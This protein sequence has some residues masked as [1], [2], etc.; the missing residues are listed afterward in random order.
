MSSLCGGVQCAAGACTCKTPELLPTIEPTTLPLDAT[1]STSSPTI[2]I[3]AGAAGSVLAA[4]VAAEVLRR[5]FWRRRAKRLQSDLQ[6][7]APVQ[8]ALVQPEA[9]V[10]Q[11][12]RRVIDWAVATRLPLQVALDQLMKLSRADEQ[13]HGRGTIGV[14]ETAQAA[15]PAEN[16][17]KAVEA[18]LVLFDKQRQCPIADGTHGGGGV[19]VFPPGILP[20][21]RVQITGSFAPDAVILAARQRMPQED[22][23]VA[24]GLAELAA[25]V[26]QL[27]TLPASLSVAIV[28]QLHASEVPTED[29][30]IAYLDGL[31][32]DTNLLSAL[33][34][35]L[36]VIADVYKVNLK[37]QAHE[38]LLRRMAS[39]VW[40]ATEHDRLERLDVSLQSHAKLSLGG[41]GG[42]DSV[43][44]TYEVHLK[45]QAHEDLLRRMASGVWGA[46][47]HDRLERL[48]VSLHR[49]L[50]A[51]WDGGGGLCCKPPQLLTAANHAHSLVELETDSGE[52]EDVL[53]RGSAQK[54][55]RVA[56]LDLVEVASRRVAA[57][58]GGCRV[59]PPKL[60][61]VA[62]E[63]LT[64]CTVSPLISDPDVPGTPL[65]VD[66][67][68]V[69]QPDSLT[70]A[71][72]VTE[73]D[74]TDDTHT[75]NTTSDALT[76]NLSQGG[77]VTLSMANAS[78]TNKMADAPSVT[79][80]V[81]T[82]S[83]QSSFAVQAACESET[84][85]ASHAEAATKPELEA[86][87]DLVEVA[88]RR[89][90]ASGGGCRVM[91]PKLLSVAAEAT[92]EMR[93]E[94]SMAA[95]ASTGMRE[96]LASMIISLHGR[97]LVNR[98]KARQRAQRWR[99][100]Q[101][102][103]EA[104]P[105]ALLQ[106]DGSVEERNGGGGMRVSPLT[107]L[108]NASALQAF[109]GSSDIHPLSNPGLPS[110]P[111]ALS[112]PPPSRTRSLAAQ[113]WKMAALAGNSN[114]SALSPSWPVPRSLPQSPPPSPPMIL[115]NPWPSSIGGPS[116]RESKLDSVAIEVTDMT[117][118]DNDGPTAAPWE[119]QPQLVG[120][121]EGDHTPDAD[122]PFLD[123]G[124][125]HTQIPHAIS[126]ALRSE[127]QRQA[128]PQQCADARGASQL[129]LMMYAQKLVRAYRR[130]G[131]IAT[132][133]TDV[134]NIPVA[135]HE[136]NGR[137][138]LAK[139]AADAVRP[140][141]I[142]IEVEP[143]VLG[144]ARK[145]L[146]P[147]RSPDTP[148]LLC[149]IE[150]AI[151][152][153][154]KEMRSAAEKGQWLAWLPGH[155][156]RKRKTIGVTPAQFDKQLKPQESTQGLIV[157]RSDMPQEFSTIESDPLASQTLVEPWDD[158]EDDELRVVSY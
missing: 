33:G 52:W 49:T 42:A 145:Q 17:R 81:P 34:K 26:N 118:E 79:P 69:G 64:G 7:L 128:S 71:I 50:E 97:H 53:I 98:L 154:T 63:A 78:A 147:Q 80:A 29:A 93:E 146:V 2:P 82:K 43:V 123:D 107:M 83:R 40:G 45:Q 27:A 39:G 67:N 144:M 37:Q 6:K 90:A 92:T 87:S 139:E 8:M 28:M 150:L 138:P 76:T 116:Q 36:P 125:E 103:M 110:L 88:S 47:E 141:L 89:V 106:A 56:R 136:A 137:E 65:N 48:N 157:R 9:T 51:G 102:Q 54:V 132:S 86:S 5:R 13:P 140:L 105:L 62:A 108:P 130:Q 101:L 59:M 68:G 109:L 61:F 120:V 133:K 74:A 66:S 12:L 46:S 18:M 84:A 35:P 14:L 23:S 11:D 4:M 25:E 115:P 121:G 94:L 3:A 131:G 112:A 142:G 158:N 20:I 38:D 126:V 155:P 100:I 24:D 122:Q 41:G 119:V 1:V 156:L 104:G 60:L 75:M 91:P 95:E 55:L 135:D 19:R 151:Y 117:A 153:R 72:S 152:D 114:A 111:F 113:K 32:N 15:F 99:D 22:G 21:P 70:D 143:D 73:L 58:G 96:E 129:E 134:K 30:Q 16:D 31:C 149:L 77:A 85:T 44:T 10:A 127:V 57:S 124:L 148:E